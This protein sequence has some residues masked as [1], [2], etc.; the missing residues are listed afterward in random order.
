MKPDLRQRSVFLSASFPSGVRG[1]A[2]PASDPAAVTDA[3]TAIVRAILAANGRLVF[4]GHPTISPLVLFVAAEQASRDRVDAYQSQWFEGE[5]PEETR[6]LEELGFGSIHWTPREPSLPQSLK[7]MREAML[8]ETR[9]S[10]A[11]FVGGM[12]GIIDEWD[13]F[14]QIRPGH[15]RFPLGAPGGA[16]VRLAQDAGA[17]GQLDV[18][19]FSPHYP[20]LAWQLVEQLAGE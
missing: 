17:A 2:F 10:G 11:L 18:D 1:E 8:A 6:R 7:V 16:S 13:L 19:L 9:P 3:V 14:G 15:L 20:A 12:E 5:I 4:G